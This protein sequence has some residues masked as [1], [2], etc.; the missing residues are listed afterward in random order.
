MHEWKKVRDNHYGLKS[1]KALN[2]VPFLISVHYNREK[3]RE[4]VKEGISK[5]IYPVRILTDDQAFLIKDKDVILV[6]RG[7]EVVI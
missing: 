2:L 1:F 5:T 6:G 3:Y 7:K 4:K